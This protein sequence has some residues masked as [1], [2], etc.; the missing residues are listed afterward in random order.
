M[1]A[2]LQ[3][4]IE[5]LTGREFVIRDRIPISGGN[6]NQTYHLSDGQQ[7]YFV[8]LN[9]ANKVG[10]F[11]A[12]AL[13]LQAIHNCQSIR[14]PQ[15]LGWG[16]TGDQSYLILEWIALGQGDQQSWRK[17]GQQLA[18]MHRH[19]SDQGWG[20]HQNNT[21]GATPQ[22]NP[23]ME[24][25]AQFYTHH[26]LG[27]QLQLAQRRGGHFTRGETLLARIPEIL[28][29]HQPQSALVHGDLW[30]GNAAFSRTGQPIILDPAVYYGDREVDIAMTKLFGGFPAAFY[31][32]YQEAWPLE[33]GYE[34]R[35][36][37]YN[38][39]HILNHF[40][41]FGGGYASQ[42]QGMMEQIL[43]VD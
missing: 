14:V 8:K 36:I 43:A 30:S 13:G 29:N 39:Y 16:I 7:D 23:W 6:I 1:W 25:W 10:M 34:K 21:I 22:L 3:Q 18:A 37:L 38:L 28:A 33:K 40:N 17:M 24:D 31:Q 12:E 5:Q 42:A 15:P 41:L 27:Y 32:G 11:E 35:Q 20:W 2:D 4:Q 19:S 9:T 26:R